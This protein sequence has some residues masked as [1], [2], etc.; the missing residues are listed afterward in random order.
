MRCCVY[1]LGCVMWWRVSSSVRSARACLAVA[2]TAFCVHYSC[3]DCDVLFSHWLE[4]RDNYPGSY[5]PLE[6]SYVVT[7][8]Y[9][10]YPGSYPGSF[11][12]VWVIPRHLINHG[13]I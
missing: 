7:T 10:S 13:K 9:S 2:L 3:T 12:A 5:Y 4:L 8:S 11:V 1:A 6:G